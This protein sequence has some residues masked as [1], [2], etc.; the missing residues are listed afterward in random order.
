MDEKRLTVPEV[1]KL[2]QVSRATVY[3]YIEKG[4]LRV[5]RM[6]TGRVQVDPQSVHEIL[7]GG[8]A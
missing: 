5:V 3:R 4:Q 8:A 6:P 7:R 1:A 2:L